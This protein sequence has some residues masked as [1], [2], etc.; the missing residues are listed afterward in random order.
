[1]SKCVARLIWFQKK[2]WRSR[3]ERFAMGCIVWPSANR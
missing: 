1:V 3:H 2:C